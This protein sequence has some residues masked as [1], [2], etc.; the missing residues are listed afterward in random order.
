MCV[1]ACVVVVVGVG[2]GGV[3]WYLSMT[4]TRRELI[5]DDNVGDEKA[6]LDRGAI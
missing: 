1:R 6:S 4:R 5:I 2:V 3:R